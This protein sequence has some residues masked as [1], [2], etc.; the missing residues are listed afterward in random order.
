[1]IDTQQET[2]I[3]LSEASKLV[4]GIN[5]RKPH[6]S[7]IWR[8]CRKG[9]RGTQLE[10]VRIGQR[11]CTSRQALDRFFN[12]LAQRDT[13]I[14]PA[15]FDKTRRQPLRTVDRRARSVARAKDELRNA[16]I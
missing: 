10:Y 1:M 11:I 16:G 8:W 4:P 7:T 14:D 5:G 3:S 15:R 9:L 12:R 13:L 2:V 6:A